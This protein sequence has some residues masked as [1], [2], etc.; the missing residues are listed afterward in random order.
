MVE[1]GEKL[2][3]DLISRDGLIGYLHEILENNE[4][5]STLLKQAN[6]VAVDRFFYNDHGITHSRIVS[7]TSIEIFERLLAH[8][9][10][11]TFVENKLGSLEDAKVIIFL[12]AYL[13]DIGNAFHRE[14]HSLV[15]S[16]LV[17]NLLDEVLIE[18]YGDLKKRTIIKSEIS[19]SIYSHDEKILAP[20]VESSIIKVA[21]GLD[22]AEGRARIPYRLGKAD[23]HAFSALAI[24]KVEIESTKEKPILIKVYMN[25]EAGLF[26]IEKVL[27]P[28]I[29]TTLIKHLVKIEAIKNGSILRTYEFD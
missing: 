3:F 14:N 21:D 2:Y 17:F 18:I 5:I 1:I 16:I 22:M 15:G 19:Q 20:S 29:Q 9:I 7:S 26:Q 23:I 11:P 24:K 12:S 27:I 6:V 10:I 4:K 28:K 13:H 8:N 25:S